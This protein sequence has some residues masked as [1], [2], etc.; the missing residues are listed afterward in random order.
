MTS[1]LKRNIVTSLKTYPAIAISGF[2]PDFNTIVSWIR[3]LN[4]SYFRNAPL[5]QFTLATQLTERK[6]DPNSSA[7]QNAPTS[8]LPPV[9]IGDDPIL[10][11]LEEF[12]KYEGEGAFVFCDLHKVLHQEGAKTLLS[13]L[14]EICVNYNSQAQAIK[15]LIILGEELTLPSELRRLIPIINFEL[16]NK[17]QLNSASLQQI[18]K[19]EL[20][21]LNSQ[22]IAQSALGLTGT[23]LLKQID[24]KYHSSVLDE[25]EITTDGLIESIIGYKTQ[26]LKSMGVD[27]MQPNRTTFG[28]HSALRDWLADVKQLI[29]PE[30]RR[31]GLPQPKGCFLFGASGC[32]KTL[33]AKSIANDWN[34]P[35][36]K[37][38]IPSLKGSLV[39]ESEKNL[40]QVLKLIQN[41]KGIILIDELEKAIGGVGSD[42]SGVSDGMFSILLDW[43]QEQNSHFVVATA[44]DVSKIPSE[45]LRAGR[46]DRQW[47]I[48]LPDEKERIEILKIHLLKAN[49]IKTEY[50]NHL[51]AIYQL[52]I[53]RTEGYSGAELE[54]LVL[55]ALNKAYLAGRPGTPNQQDFMSSLTTPL[56]IL[57]PEKYQR[58][59]QGG[60]FAVPTKYPENYVANSQEDPL[61]IY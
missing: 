23:E 44:N 8:V 37:L 11:Y 59:K 36:I 56:A 14:H 39:G 4:G 12:R 53:S 6:I 41:L 46:L 54:E 31:Y 32:G 16:P 10:H 42:S 34:L 45:A 35:L 25:I 24:K 57:H 5:Y 7:T 38:N 30:A 40:R 3:N 33:V 18:K 1:E 20:E 19:W 17:D 15:R 22:K 2:A 47:F 52:I 13:L 27:V 43:M 49:R 58:I 50:A 51:T 26:L 61:G 48:D 29:K 28:G 21:N 55:A 60:R 9:E